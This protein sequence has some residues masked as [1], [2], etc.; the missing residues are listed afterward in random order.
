MSTRLSFLFYDK[1]ICPFGWRIY[2]AYRRT[3]N[4]DFYPTHNVFIWLYSIHVFFQFWGKGR[5]LYVTRTISR[6]GYVEICILYHFSFSSLL[7]M[8]RTSITNYN[9]RVS[10]TYD[11]FHHVFEITAWFTFAKIFSFL[12]KYCLSIFDLVSVSF[13]LKR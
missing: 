7:L 8:V 1:A 10:I 5:W 2:Y 13:N 11:V 6:N 4:Q 12:A 9:C 3:C